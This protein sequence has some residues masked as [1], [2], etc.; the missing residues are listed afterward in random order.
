MVIPHL[1]FAHL[2]SDYILQ[3]DWLVARKSQAW[4]GIMLHGL[5]VLGMSTVAVAPY[6]GQMFLPL[7]VLWVG[8]TAQDWFKLWTGRRWRRYLIASY[9][10]DQI[11]HVTLIGGIQLWVNAYADIQARDMEVFTFSLL[12][13]LV[14]VTR[15]Y[16]VSWWAN[17]FE[18]IV[19]MNRWQLWGYAERSLMLLLAVLGMGGAVIA[20]LVGLSRLIWAWRRGRPLWRQ[21]YGLWEW[22]LGVAVSIGLGWGVLHSLAGQSW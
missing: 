11:A 6:S 17:W 22:G 19:Y 9:F 8:H 18:M 4:D 16:E 15:M 12:A 13:A 10:A 14:A 3:T 21:R 7:L 2:V 5:I 20:L 1:I